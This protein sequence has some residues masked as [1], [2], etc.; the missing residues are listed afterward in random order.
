MFHYEQAFS[1]NLGWL[2]EDEQAVLRR[3]RVAIAGL[4]GVG[5]QH[6]QTLARLG[7]GAFSLAD[8]DDFDWP[9]FNRQAGAYASTVGQPKL[10][11]MADFA[12]GIN[13][14]LDLRCFPEGV[15]DENI[16][17]FLEGVDLYVDGLDF[18]VLDVRRKVFQACARK[19]IPAVTAAPMGMST[20]VVVFT[21]ESMSFDDYF[22]LTGEE[23]TLEAIKFLIG[24]SP[25]MLHRGYLVDDRF[26]SLSKK[27]GPSTVM[28]CQLCAGTAATE[29]LK[30]LLGRGCLKPAP[31]SYQFDAYRL[32]L[33][34]VWRPWGH[35]NP[36][37]RL[38]T[39]IAAWQIARI[40]KGAGDER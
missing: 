21:P 6:L 29:A 28:A 16:D 10:E 33:K 35:R 39:R 27:K 36:L 18:F 14:E 1:R 31:H 26:V 2:T 24:L 25:A 34:H 19:G 9:N 3:K 32:K 17:R 8:F 40:E 11:V 4:G 20:A 23:N 30:L 7:I 5:G 38:A 13:P 12:R 22:G 37:Q 15:L